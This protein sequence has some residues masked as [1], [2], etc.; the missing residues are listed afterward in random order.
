MPYTNSLKLILYGIF[1]IFCIK[2]NKEFSIFIKISDWGIF[3][4]SDTLFRN[5]QFVLFLFQK[6]G[7]NPLLVHHENSAVYEAEYGKA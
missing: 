5:V 2:H 6:K 3:P 4:N 7:V 1:I